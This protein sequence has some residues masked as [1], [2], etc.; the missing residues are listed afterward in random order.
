MKRALVLVL[1]VAACGGSSGGDKADPKASYVAAAE[2]VCSKAN[3][4][5]AA[6]KKEQPADISKV[7]A[8]VHR[9][10]DIARQNVTDVSALTPP[11]KDAADV[12]AKLTGP[13]EQQLADGDAFA[14]KVDAAAAKKDNAGLFNLVTHPPTTTRVDVPWMKSYGF[15]ACV[16]AADTGAAAK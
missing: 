5:L 10:V 15:S 8:Y 9:L 11:E 2:K 12:K 6:A 16:T 7:P 3:E 4:Q 13:L 14:A 1:L